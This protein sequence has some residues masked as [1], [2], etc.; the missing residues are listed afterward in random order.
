MG[1]IELRAHWR[2]GD[3][4]EGGGSRVPIMTAYRQQALACAYA[5]AHQSQAERSDFRRTQ[6]RRRDKGSPLSRH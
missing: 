6:Q 1:Y 5:R 3:P 2:Q 4:A